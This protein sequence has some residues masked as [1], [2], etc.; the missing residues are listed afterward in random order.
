MTRERASK[1]YEGNRQ[2]RVRTRARSCIEDRGLKNYRELT[3][4]DGS[5]WSRQPDRRR[6]DDR[7][8]I[9][10]YARRKE[11]NLARF[12]AFNSV[13]LSASSFPPPCVTVFPRNTESYKNKPQE[14]YV[15]SREYAAKLSVSSRS[16]PVDRP[17]LV[18]L[19]RVYGSRVK[20]HGEFPCDR[21]IKECAIYRGYPVCLQSKLY[22]PL[23]SSSSLD[24]SLRRNG[25]Q[26]GSSGNE[27]KR[28]R[29][30]KK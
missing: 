9:V 2:R 4:Q 7:S 24:E 1:I 27:D 3:D 25:A 17:S 12:S 15:P 18:E 22:R 11:A 13:P 23:S 16:S 29:R 19:N 10:Y 21:E 8:S 14:T 26:H 30:K 28:K 5:L 20:R 6:S